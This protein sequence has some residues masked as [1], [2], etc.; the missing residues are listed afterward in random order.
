MD[1]Y[2]KLYSTNLKR[3][4]NQITNE[5]ILENIKSIEEKISQMKS[6]LEE[7]EKLEKNP[8][9]GKK[10]ME[11]NLAKNPQ[12]SEMF[13]LSKFSLTKIQENFNCLTE[14]EKNNSKIQI[15]HSFLYINI[16][17]DKAFEIFVD[18]YNKK[19]DENLNFNLLLKEF[20][21]RFVSR[22]FELDRTIYVK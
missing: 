17:I 12:I 16:N 4:Y 15:E 3:K 21:E 7:I 19:I 13:D 9:S 22:I 20:T 2:T 11:K 6:S 14:E 18:F 5:I 1:E 10:N 8:S